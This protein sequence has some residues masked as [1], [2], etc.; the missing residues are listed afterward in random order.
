MSS[1]LPRPLTLGVGLATLLEHAG[2]LCHHSVVELEIGAGAVIAIVV[3]QRGLLV[4]L[5]SLNVTRLHNWE[6]AHTTRDAYGAL[7]EV[8][9]ER[10]TTGKGSSSCGI[11]AC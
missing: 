4:E 10:F 3:D 1:L 7:C 2:Q 8:K 6:H 5:S 11:N 9:G